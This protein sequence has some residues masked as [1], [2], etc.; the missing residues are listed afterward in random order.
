MIKV[1]LFDLD[2]T[3]YNERDF[4]YSGFMAVAKYISEKHGLCI[5][6]VYEKILDIFYKKGRGRIF[7]ILCEMYSIEEDIHT[8]VGIY[9]ETKPSIELYED[10]RYILDKLKGDYQLGIITD[11]KNTVQ[12]SK[13]KALGIERYMDKII[14]T[15]DHGRD[16]WKPSEKPYQAM[17]EYFGGDPKE[18]VYIG[19]NPHKDFISC[20]KLGM[21]TVRVIRELG[22]HMQVCLGDQY[23]ADYNVNTLYELESIFNLL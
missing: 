13:I 5:E 18:F 17:L 14:V 4:V 10:A 12:W 11:G 2:D 19:D 21:H 15:D 6:E 9:R 16:Y 20:K 1:V 23:E 7:N 3:L 8:L 22:D